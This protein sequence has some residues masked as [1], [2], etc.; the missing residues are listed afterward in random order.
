MKNPEVKKILVSH[1]ISGVDLMKDLDKDR[2]GVVSVLEFVRG[3]VTLSLS[4]TDSFH[5]TEGQLM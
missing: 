3:M 5:R 4:S 1:G 2:N